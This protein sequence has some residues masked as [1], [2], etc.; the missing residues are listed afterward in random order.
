MNRIRLD[1]YEMQDHIQHKVME[2]WDQINTDNVN[3]LADLTGYW[4]DF[5]HMFGFRY[6][7]IDYSKDV[8]I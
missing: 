7:N 1:D 2:L 6:E 5:Y 8:E 4:E 3:E